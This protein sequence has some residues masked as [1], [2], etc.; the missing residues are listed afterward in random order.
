MCNPLITI[1]TIFIYS[2][3]IVIFILKLH[4]TNHSYQKTGYKTNI[5]LTYLYSYTLHYL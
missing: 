5:P 3:R 2:I 4:F 1:S